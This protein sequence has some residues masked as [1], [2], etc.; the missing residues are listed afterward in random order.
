[1]KNLSILVIGLS[2]LICNVKAVALNSSDNTG[3]ATLVQNG[4]TAFK[5]SSSQEL[6]H[7]AQ[8]WVS[9]FKQANPS[10]EISLDQLQPVAAMASNHLGLISGSETDILNNL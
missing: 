5:V 3:K 1:M 10:V 7:L 9:E 6:F 2:L 8:T 4:T